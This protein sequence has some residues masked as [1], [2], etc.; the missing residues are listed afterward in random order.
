MIRHAALLALA[1]GACASHPRISARIL[2]RDGRPI[3]GAVLYV[4]TARP[5]PDFDDATD[6][7]W[8][9]SGP[10]GLAPAAGDPV[11]TVEVPWRGMA[12]VVALASGYLPSVWH[13]RNHEADGDVLGIQEIRMQPREGSQGAWGLE[14]L[15]W[16]TFRSAALKERCMRPEHA[17]LRSVMRA[18]WEEGGSGAVLSETQQKKL[19]AQRNLP[20]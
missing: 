19:A 6:F 15:S 16:P 20:P 5:G 10:D 11:V 1:L 18:V 4:E 13:L 12:S 7:A 2:D 8:A 9:R 3:P 17:D 14:T